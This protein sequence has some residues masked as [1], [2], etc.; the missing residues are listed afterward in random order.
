MNFGLL[1]KNLKHSLSKKIFEDF[2]KKTNPNINYFL[3]EV[4]D[5]N[6][7]Y[8]IIRE[9]DL[10]GFNI[11]SPYKVEI[12]SYLDTIDSIAKEIGAVNV[13]KIKRENGNLKLL[14]F[15]TDYIGFTQAYWQIIRDVKDTILI[16]GTGGAAKSV[17]YALLK[18][19]KNNFYFVSRKNSTNKILNYKDLENLNLNIGLIINATSI[20]IYKNDSDI[21]LPEIIFKNKPFF[22]DLNYNPEITYFMELAMLH[23][24][25]VL[26]GYSML[27]LQ[28]KESWKIWGLI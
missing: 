13:V 18:L 14:G 26:N 15:N 21:Y 27:I 5:L 19:N 2:L 28:A 10:F 6:N 7:L 1:G 17:A 25:P 24:C 4:D 9:F 3:I 11:T 8:S 16:L 23:K 22:I 20:G 12:I